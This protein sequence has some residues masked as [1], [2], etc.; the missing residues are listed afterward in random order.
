[1]IKSNNDKLFRIELTR[2][3]FRHSALSRSLKSWTYKLLD[4]AIAKSFGPLHVANPNRNL[5]CHMQGS[6]FVKIDTRQ[7]TLY[8]PV[9]EQHYKECSTLVLVSLVFL[10]VSGLLF[11]KSVRTGFNIF[12]KQKMSQFIVKPSWMKNV[13]KCDHSTKGMCSGPRSLKILHKHN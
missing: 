2:Q 11:T 5:Y 12:A 7:L 8:R 4:P 10:S 1:M 3:V 6:Y 9:T 13:K